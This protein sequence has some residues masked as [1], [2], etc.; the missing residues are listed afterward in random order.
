[1]HKLFRKLSQRELSSLFFPLE[2]LRRRGEDHV[3]RGIEGGLEGVL[4][5]AH[6]EAH[7]DDLH[8]DI[9]G[10]AEER[11]GKR[12]QKERAA[13]DAGSAAGREGRDDA[14]EQRDRQGD[15]RSYR[16][17]GGQRKGGDDR[18]GSV[19]ID[20]GAERDRDRVHVLVEAELFAELQVD[21][22]VGGRASGEEG[23]DAALADAGQDQR[24]RVVPERDPDDQR[25][26][27]SRDR[28]WR[29]SRRRGP[30]Y[31]RGRS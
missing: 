4:N 25:W 9:I 28:S 13:G 23:G 3:A 30:E 7:A 5:D 17:G 22:D 6:D 26:L 2:E 10:N 1:M 19:H 8:R 20:G 21:R 11:A 24:E 18:C 15:L 14:E 12:N 29:R 16:V 31:R 27:R